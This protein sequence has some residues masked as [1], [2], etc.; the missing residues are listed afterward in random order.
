MSSRNDIDER[1]ESLVSEL[2]SGLVAASPELRARVRAIAEHA[3]E[4]RQRRGP[5]WSHFGWRRAALVLVPA[6]LVAA[7][8]AALLHGLTSPGA[9]PSAADQV[10][11]RAAVPAPAHGGAVQP[12]G[13]TAAKER[14]AAAP[15]PSARL[16]DYRVTMRV[17]VGGI[18]SLSKSVVKAMRVTRSLGGYVANV[19][20]STPSVRHGDAVLVLRVP[21]ANIQ[22]AVLA[23]AG[24][25]SLVAQ[26]FSVVDVQ[27]RYDTQLQRIADLR[28][29][30]AKLEAQ[31]ADG[32]LD[33]V[34]RAHV[35]EQ[36]EYSRARLT[37][38]SAENRTTLNHARLS[39]ARLTLTTFQKRQ[40]QVVPPVP[41]R[42]DRTLG[43]AGRILRDEASVT[44]YALVVAGPFLLFALLL[45]AAERSRRRRVERRLLGATR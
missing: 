14:S 1:F 17:R 36:L 25:G 37:R 38:L 5:L 22:K 6:C 19:A 29:V 28:A 4:P 43:D 42:F 44:L 12:Y 10:F 9:K 21:I 40:K 41:G 13:A 18:D 33:D 39:T 8:G 32:G 16:Q 24:L 2:R 3:P 15:P 31:L 7:A 35:Q 11:S 26:H 20:Y 34:D 45:V 27:K 23:Y 30:I